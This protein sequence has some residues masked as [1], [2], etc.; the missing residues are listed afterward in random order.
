MSSACA[1]PT[2]AG[3]RVGIGS[4]IEGDLMLTCD[5]IWVLE[6]LIFVRGG[7]LTIE[8]GTTIVGTEGSALVIDQDAM[9]VAEGTEDAPIV[10]TSIQSEGSR[11]RGDWGGL[12]L[13]GSATTN[14]E[15][16]VGT[17]EGFANAPAYGGQDDADSCGSLAYVRVE[18]AGF[19]IAEGSELNGITFYACGSS[20]SMHHVQV[21]MGAD[22]GIEMFG[23]TF[24][25]DHLIVTGAEDDS[26]DCDQ[27]YRGTLTD[28]FVHQDPAVGDN[29]L[30]WSN[31]G[32]NIVATPLTSPTL[33]NGTLVGSGSG[34]DSSKGATFKE[35]TEAAIHNTVFANFTNELFFLQN[36][37]TQSNAERGALMISGNV[38]VGNGAPRVDAEG[39]VTWSAED[40]Q[41]FL[42][43]N[44]N[45]AVD[46]MFGSADWGSPNISPLE[47]S[48]V[49]GASITTSACP[50]VGYVGAVEP[51]GEN[52]TAA[53]WTN[54]AI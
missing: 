20:T 23:G 16:G 26:F 9:I 25:A 21:H 44:M 48:P 33:C 22:D 52:W 4:D 19:A 8:A 39:D 41:S 35:G 31:Q 51:G 30:E 54:Y 15:G 18:W 7:T 45:V 43:D 28:V 42:D 29:G 24:D 37:E 50:D 32:T 14:L 27:G 3:A 34:G 1:E 53:S 13:L 17:A 49:A 2:D 6:D 36:I 46:P 40:F 38:Y 5:T 11:S 47:G 12:V 10:M